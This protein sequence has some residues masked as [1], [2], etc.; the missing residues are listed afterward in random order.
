MQI[1]GWKAILPALLLGVCCGNATAQKSLG[2]EQYMDDFDTIW[3][4]LGSRYAYFD[5]KEVDWNRVRELFRPKIAHVKSRS[6]FIS[7]LEKVLDELYDNHTS[8]NTNLP[9]SPRLV[10]SGADIW[11]EW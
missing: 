10:P 11:A 9:T 6:N 4:E 3:S 1:L 2:P 7:V 5:R 8:L